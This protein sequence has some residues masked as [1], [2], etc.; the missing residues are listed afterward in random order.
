[1]VTFKKVVRRVLV[2]DKI[3]RKNKGS[4]GGSPNQSSTR[5]SCRGTQWPWLCWRYSRRVPW[6]SGAESEVEGRRWFQRDIGA[7][8]GGP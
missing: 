7:K 6:V 2:S 5:M 8:S 1:M 4:K 3:L